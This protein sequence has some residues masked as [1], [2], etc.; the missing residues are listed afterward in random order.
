MLEHPLAD[1]GVLQGNPVHEENTHIAR[2]AGCDFI[3][4]V[5]LDSHRRITSV[6]AG[7]M[8]QAFLRGVEVVRSV[9]R[10][11]VSR[12]C[13]IVVTSSA[14][15][16]LDT[17]FYQSIKGLVGV[18]PIVAEGGTIILAASLSEGIGSPEFQQLFRDF[19]SLDVFLE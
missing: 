7:D 2:M 5:T 18:L 9:A 1:C 6:A 13:E 19:D 10:A 8:E 15:Y 17:T 4:N 12:P 3:V 11:E 16:P 14:G